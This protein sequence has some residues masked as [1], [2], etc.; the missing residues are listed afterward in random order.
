MFEIKFYSNNYT[1]TQDGILKQKDRERKIIDYLPKKSI[2]HHSLITTF[3]VNK[4]P[5]SSY[6][7]NVITIKDLLN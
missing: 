6:F 2:V 5:Y 4:N 7:M 1:V 3:G